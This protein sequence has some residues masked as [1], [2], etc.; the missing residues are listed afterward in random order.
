MSKL[1]WH[2]LPRAEPLI[3]VAVCACGDTA[4]RLARRLLEYDEERL[5]QLR[6]V[7]ARRTILLQGETDVLPWVDGAIYL[8][9]DAAAPALLLPTQWTPSVP[10]DWLER[11]FR[12][13]APPPLALLRDPLQALPLGAALPVARARVTAWL[14][15]FG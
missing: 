4:A 3:P 1:A 6:G 12:R 9:R 8:G 13:L 5:A 7:G 10:I 15:Q 11:A 14:A 2:W